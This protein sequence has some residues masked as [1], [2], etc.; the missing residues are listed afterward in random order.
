LEQLVGSAPQLGGGSSIWAM[1]TLGR[2]SVVNN[3]SEA[4][5]RGRR[6]VTAK[7]PFQREFRRDNVVKLV[8]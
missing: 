1:V 2:Q 6:F 3:N 8:R 7:S 4:A 5:K